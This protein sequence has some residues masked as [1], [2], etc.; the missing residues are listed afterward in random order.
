MSLRSEHNSVAEI[1]VISAAQCPAIQLRLLQEKEPDVEE[2]IFSLND[3]LMKLV[4]QGQGRLFNVWLLLLQ[5]SKLNSYSSEVSSCRG[6]CFEADS[7]INLKK[8]F[9]PHLSSRRHGL[10]VV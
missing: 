8:L 2:S 1:Q 9:P 6:C 7:D 4:N 3:H 10:P 5:Q